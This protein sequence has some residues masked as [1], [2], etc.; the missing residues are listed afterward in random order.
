MPAE[1]G[2]AQRASRRQYLRR[3]LAT[4]AGRQELRRWRR[5]A[6]IL[7][8]HTAVVAAAASSGLIATSPDD[9]RAAWHT[10]AAARSLT[11]EAL[12]AIAAAA[13]AAT[14]PLAVSTARIT[15]RLRPWRPHSGT[16][17]VRLAQPERLKAN[18][19]AWRAAAQAQMLAEAAPQTPQLRHKPAPQTPPRAPA[20]EERQAL[21]PPQP[22]PQAQEAPQAPQEPPQAQ[23]ALQAPQEP[24]Q[25]QEA[26]QAPQPPP[27]PPPQA[28]Q[29]PP[30]AQEAPQAPQEPTQ[31]QEAPQA[32]QPPPPEGAPQ[33]PPEQARVLWLYS[34]N[35]EMSHRRQS[36][37]VF[38]VFNN[39]ACHQVEAERIL[40]VSG[41]ALRGRLR[42]AADD[43]WTRYEAHNYW[44]LDASVTTDLEILLAAIEDSDEAFAAKVAARM[45]PPVPTLRD[46]WIDDHAGGPT[47]RERLRAG[48]DD[49]LAGAAERWPHNRAFPD[50]ADRLYEDG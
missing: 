46:D 13:L 50:A 23:E 7:A 30:Q 12:A 38:M 9:F 24:P 1:H 4:P 43:G 15:S 28:P 35:E 19:P 6:T 33:Q 29:E 22:P 10:A 27:Q 5:F 3:R 16:P 8:L 25:A 21:P 47:P 11:A 32:P 31:A 34:T 36:V 44:T 42:R 48:A 49:A 41:P 17:P 14:L 2:P 26:P 45:G 20:P 37:L 40:G 39:R 18:W